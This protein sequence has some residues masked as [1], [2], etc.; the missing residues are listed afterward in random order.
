M[1]IDVIL[2]PLTTLLEKYIEKYKQLNKKLSYT[3][4][5]H[6]IEEEEKVKI[7]ILITNTNDLEMF[8]EEKI[9]SNINFQ[10]KLKKLENFLLFGYTLINKIL[11]KDL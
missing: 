4:T 1:G 10:T 11:N 2:I 6:Y 9:F 5:P 8:Y 7:T 3:I